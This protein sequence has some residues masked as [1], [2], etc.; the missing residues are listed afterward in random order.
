MG[1]FP[2]CW[3]RIWLLVRDLRDY[4]WCLAIL[5]VDSGSGSVVDGLGIL[6]GT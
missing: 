1:N 2:L 6:E 5:K 4:W 3:V